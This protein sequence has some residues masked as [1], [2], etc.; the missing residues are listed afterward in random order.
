[1]FI[2]LLL[3][4]SACGDDDGG[5]SVTTKQLKQLA[6]EWNAES[7]TFDAEPQDGYADFTLRMTVS[8]EKALYVITG[9]P[10][11][12]PWLLSGT[13]IPDQN[14]PEARLVREDDVNISYTVSST[15]LI[16]NFVYIDV[17]EGGRSKSVGGDWTFTFRKSR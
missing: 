8:G 9:S 1:M 17:T 11:R 7:V 15:A 14:N 2:V 6:G 4:A 5:E 3:S 13:L 16:M 12:T 10:E